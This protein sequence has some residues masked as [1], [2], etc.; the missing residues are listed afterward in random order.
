[1]AAHVG[2]TSAEKQRQ[3][4]FYN[5]EAEAGRLEASVDHKKIDFSKSKG[6]KYLKIQ[7]KSLGLEKW[8][9]G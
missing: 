9:T 2:K 3:R 4:D 1:M 6:K 8:L 5:L 7:I